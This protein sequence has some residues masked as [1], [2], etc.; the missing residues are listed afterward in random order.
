MCTLHSRRSVHTANL[1]LDIFISFIG[2]QF[3]CTILI[4]NHVW[5]F[6]CAIFS[7]QLKKRGDISF[8]YIFVNF[9][10]CF[11]QRV[12]PGR[13]CADHWQFHKKRQ[14]T[15]NIVFWKR[16]KSTTSNG[17]IQL[18]FQTSWTNIKLEFH[19][20]SILFRIILNFLPFSRRTKFLFQI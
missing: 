6:F 15:E 17:T 1:S 4:K 13:K 3:I 14:K 10:R 18:I 16:Y 12:F 7:I 9:E 19:W 20:A 2:I 8:Y 5:E 11:W